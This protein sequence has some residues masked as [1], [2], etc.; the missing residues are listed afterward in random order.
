M[1]SITEISL[2][3]FAILLFVSLMLAQVHLGV[4]GVIDGE[5]LTNYPREV[6]DPVDNTAGYIN[7]IAR[8]ADGTMI[9]GTSSGVF[10]FDGAKWTNYQ[11]S[12]N[13]NWG[14][15]FS[16]AIDKDGATWFGLWGGVRVKDSSG[17]WTSHNPIIG[18]GST[19]DI[20]VDGNNH[21]WIGTDE[22]G[23]AYYDGSTW[24]LYD[25]D[26][27]LVGN[28]II[29][30]GVAPDGKVW[31]G[32]NGQGVSVF[33]G[34]NWT[35]YTSQNSAIVSDRIQDFAFDDQGNVW[36]LQ[37]YGGPVKYDGTSFTSYADDPMLTPYVFLAY[38]VAVSDSNVWVTSDSGIARFDGTQWSLYLDADSGLIENTMRCNDIIIEPNGTKW[39]A[40]LNGVTRVGPALEPAE[41]TL[42]DESFEETTTDWTQADIDGDGYT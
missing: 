22:N 23:V 29:A 16:I 3:K 27:G 39:F 8:A 20:A 35:A 18:S 10:E 26:N 6:M 15:V 30:I 9:F 31:V 12:E 38:A 17:N 14:D 28:Q 32:T 34:T 19:N 40:G 33:D 37:A 11:A 7:A 21:I 36:I 5:V 41:T 24:T 25:T 13:P 42:I 4:A 1:R 2:T